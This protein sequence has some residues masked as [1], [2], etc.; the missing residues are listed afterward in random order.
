VRR[1]L[2]TLAALALALAAVPAHA[3]VARTMDHQQL[4]RSIYVA[5]A[6]QYRGAT[7]DMGFRLDTS[8][9]GRLRQAWQIEASLDLPARW[10]NRYC[11]RAEIRVNGLTTRQAGVMCDTNGDARLEWYF[12]D[13]WL[14]RG[15]RV[16]AWFSDRVTR[17]AITHPTVTV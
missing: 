5:D 2:L 16:T 17:Y 1:T 3:E 11:A 15:D 14:R 9:R 4:V 8:P 10:T 12:G 6:S 13:L 7:S